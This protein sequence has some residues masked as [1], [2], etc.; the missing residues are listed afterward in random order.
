M[1]CGAGR[2]D[3][4]VATCCKASCS[5]RAGGIGLGGGSERHL[6]RW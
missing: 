3:V 5:Y 4:T 1:R 2:E 6:W